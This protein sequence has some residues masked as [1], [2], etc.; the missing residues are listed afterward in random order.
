MN[1]IAAAG[2]V[3]AYSLDQPP[4]HFS[5]STTFDILVLTEGSFF[6]FDFS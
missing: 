6:H 1:K 5:M 3:R 4:L 2:Q